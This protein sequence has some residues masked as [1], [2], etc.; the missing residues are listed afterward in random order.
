VVARRQLAGFHLKSQGQQKY[1]YLL[2]LNGRRSRAAH[3]L[4]KGNVANFDWSPDGQP[5]C[6]HDSDL[7]TTKK[8][9]MIRQKRFPMG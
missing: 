7:K 4:L 6:L 1:L 9:K 3:G 2:R 5:D 8:K